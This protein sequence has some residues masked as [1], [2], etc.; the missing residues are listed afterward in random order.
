VY[1][2]AVPGTILIATGEPAEFV[3]TSERQ[4]AGGS[5]LPEVTMAV[6]RSL[7]ATVAGSCA[8]TRVPRLTSPGE[9]ASL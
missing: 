1:S 5:A 9:T 8:A 6:M 3:T 2:L 7:P 4:T